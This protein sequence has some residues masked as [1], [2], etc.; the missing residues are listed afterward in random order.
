MKQKNKYRIKFYIKGKQF[1]V[2][3]MV[4]AYSSH[5]VFVWANCNYKVDK[6]DYISKIKTTWK[7]QTSK[8]A[9]I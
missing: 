4:D 9:S 8:M 2:I 3:S 1:P 7:I 6:I 5:D